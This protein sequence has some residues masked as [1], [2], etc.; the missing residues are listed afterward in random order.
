MSTRMNFSPA[1]LPIQTIVNNIK[2][3]RKNGLDLNPIYQRGL[4]WN[5]DF[6]EKLIYSIIK[7]YP[8]GNISIRNLEMAN[9]INAKSETVDGKQRLSTIL[10]FMDDD[11]IIKGEYAS[12][13]LEEI[14]EYF[15]N[16]NDPLSKKLQRKYLSKG[17]ITLKFS[18]LPD[19]V[20]MNINSFPLSITNIS[21]ATDEQ[22]TEYF[23]F[24]QN[25]ERLRAGEIINSIP[26][27][28]LQKYLSKISD[29]DK[30]LEI[31]SFNDNRMEFDKIF[32]SLIGLFEK[33]INFG[34]TDKV[35][36]DYVESK[37][38]EL[39]PQG[40]VYV[41]NMIQN[42][43]YIINQVD[44]KLVKAN[45]R[46][47]KLLLLMTGFYP[48]FLEHETKLK[49]VKLEEINNKISAFNSA[50]KGMV[51]E[52]FAG[53]SE[54]CIESYRLIALLSKGAHPFDRVKERID[55]LIEIC[56]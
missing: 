42:I 40:E 55:I 45:K 9:G 23:N 17:K 25:Q 19:M 44:E 24:L 8:I 43:N 1:A 22:I 16:E 15:I 51:E 49:L 34:V 35:I 11:L 46:Y 27:T 21:N 5:D 13:I 54:S 32:Y 28:K 37:D 48:K 31:L 52:T 53:Y 29:K 56:K 50:K 41:N 3:V 6:K 4:V 10:E 36:K 38:D 12:K 39:T 26:D 47:L 20:K 18:E 14:Q 30:F 2:N 7:N 33:A